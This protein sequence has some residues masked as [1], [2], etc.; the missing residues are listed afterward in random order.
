M[1][2]AAEEEAGEDL[3]SLIRL[4]APPS[5]ALSSLIWRLNYGSSYYRGRRKVFV[6]SD[7]ILS[8]LLDLPLDFNRRF[9]LR[10][11]R[12]REINVPI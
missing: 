4:S 5:A 11:R 2:L 9:A 12:R 10:R 3:V 6:S 7:L 8:Q 1:S